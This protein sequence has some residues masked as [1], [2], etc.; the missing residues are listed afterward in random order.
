MCC[1]ISCNV[2]GTQAEGNAEDA[3]LRGFPF[4]VDWL[5]QW[6]GDVRN[7]MGITA[8]EAQIKNI[9]ASGGGGWDGS[10]GVCIN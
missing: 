3:M 10:C 4:Y 2:Q 1:Q 6:V 9:H 8:N 7:P 5:L